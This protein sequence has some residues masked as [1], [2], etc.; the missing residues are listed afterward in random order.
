MFSTERQI[1]FVQ[2]LYFCSSCWRFPGFVI[3][4]NLQLL[5]AAVIS[6]F[7]KACDVFDIFAHA[8][9]LYLA[10]SVFSF[11]FPAS[12]LLHVVS[13]RWTLSLRFHIFLPFLCEQE[14]YFSRKQCGNVLFSPF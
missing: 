4:R 9:V 1:R 2:C 14:P 10:V 5:L 7:G 3:L 12:S 13:S 11:G 8:S 6:S